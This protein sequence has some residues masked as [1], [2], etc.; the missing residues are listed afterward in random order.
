MVLVSSGETWQKESYHRR[1]KKNPHINLSLDSKQFLLRPRNCHEALYRR[2]NVVPSYFIPFCLDF[3]PFFGALF[4]YAKKVE[5]HKTVF[6]LTVPVAPS[7]WHRPR[8]TVSHGIP[9]HPRGT[10][11]PHDTQKN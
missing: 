3:Q 4:G 9:W 8:G 1:V 7:P 11:S 2:P 6:T 10:A 5:M